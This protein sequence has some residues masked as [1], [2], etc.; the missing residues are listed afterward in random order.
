MPVKVVYLR[1]NYIES[2]LQT[3][4]TYWSSFYVKMWEPLG[5][6]F[7]DTHDCKQVFLTALGS[8]RSISLVGYSVETFQMKFWCSSN[9]HPICVLQTL[10]TVPRVGPCSPCLS[11]NVGAFWLV[12]AIEYLTRG[13]GRVRITPIVTGLFLN[14]VSFA[15]AIYYAFQPSA[16]LR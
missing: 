2:I 16:L 7:N 12:R 9:V 4:P 14:S 11:Q 13:T 1:E 5:H 10:K 6:P 8:K 3:A 15:Q